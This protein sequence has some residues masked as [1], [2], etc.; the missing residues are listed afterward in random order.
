MNNS[1]A[2][3]R[4]KDSAKRQSAELKRSVT[5]IHQN[6]LKQI[7]RDLNAL[8]DKRLKA[9]QKRIDEELEKPQ[10]TPWTLLSIIGATTLIVGLIVGAWSMKELGPKI[11]RDTRDTS[12]D[13]KLIEANVQLKR[14]EARVKELQ[15][16]EIPQD[17]KREDEDG[18]Y[19]RVP[20]SSIY[21]EQGSTNK[22]V[23]FRR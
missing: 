9:M 14:L 10:P 6:G 17:M 20:E 8:H 11:A 18:K 7:V 19:V 12:A 22:W 3:K 13:Q 1:E 4:L 23:L 15:A 16:W 5:E 21:N 2:L